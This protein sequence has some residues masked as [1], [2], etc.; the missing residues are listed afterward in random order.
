MDGMERLHASARLRRLGERL[1]GERPTLGEVFADLGDRAPGFL[2]LALAVPAIVPTPGVPAGFVFGTI[3]SLIAIQMIVGRGRLH[4]PD[5]LARRRIRRTVLSAVLA[6]ATPM[7]ERIENRLLP[8][9]PAMVRAG[10]LRPLGLVVLVMGVLIALPIPLGNTLP[11]LAV[12]VI[13][14]GLI[15]GDGLAVLAGL[16]I[17]V[18]AA[19]TSIGLVFGT[20]W[21][22]GVSPI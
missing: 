21:L 6:R 5:W 1:T 22:I 11:G 20:M 7:I 17:G 8:R 10:M 19:V 4:V 14:L 12:I 2:L 13:A 9:Y 15:V 18:L 3:L 16:G